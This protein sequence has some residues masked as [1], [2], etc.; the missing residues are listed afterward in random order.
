MRP[1]VLYDIPS[2]LPGNKWSPNPAKPRYETGLPFETVWVEYLD[3]APKMQE[4]GEAQNKLPDGHDGYTVP[5]LSDLNT[6]ALITD[7]FE[8][9][10]YL[11]KTY[12]EKS[13][14]PTNSVGLIN[15]FDSAY[16]ALTQPAVQPVQLRSS[17]ILNERSAEYF[18]RM[19]TAMHQQHTD[20]FSPERPKRDA[21]LVHYEK[22]YETAKM[23]YEK[24]GGKWLM[25][26]TIF[27]ADM[28]V[29]ARLL[30]FKRVFREDE[31]KRVCSWH[32][33]K[34]ENPLA[35]VAKERNFA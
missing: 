5:V 11:D 4:L 18:I 19:R 22:G 26:D 30:W 32:D 14:F 20:E 1:L 29:A 34:W 12:P 35:A 3:I 23:W 8:I 10:E 21:P 9:A 15:A 33:G 16:V 27:Y 6:G 17:Q 7:S 31:W 25:G 2:K 24:S 28:I 13:V